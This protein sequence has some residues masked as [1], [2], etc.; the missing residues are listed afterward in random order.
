MMRWSTSPVEVDELPQQWRCSPPF[1]FFSDIIAQFFLASTNRAPIHRI[2]A[3]MRRQGANLLVAESVLSRADVIEEISALDAR[4]NGGGGEAQAIA[5]SFFKLSKGVKSLDQATEPNLLAHAVL[6]NYRVKGYT[7]F[8]HSYIY[9][10]ILP[11]PGKIP[12]RPLDFPRTLVQPMRSFCCTVLNRTFGITG[13]LYCQQND[14][15][16]VCAHSCLRMA[17]GST[18]HSTGKI[19]SN[20]I[21][22]LLGIRDRVP[23]LDSGQIAEVI[24]ACGLKA[25]VRTKLQPDEYL[26]ELAALIDSGY[27]ALLGFTTKQEKGH[28]NMGHVVMAFGH[29]RNASQWHAQAIQTYSGPK[30]S[31]YLPSSSWIDNFFI[32]DDNLGPYLSLSARSFMRNPVMKLNCVIGLLPEPAISSNHAEIV[33]SGV[34]QHLLPLL[35]EDSSNFWLRYLVDQRDAPILRSVLMTK[36]E[37]IEHLKCS[38][39]HDRSRMDAY[40]LSKLGSLDG[41][42]WMVEFSLPPLYTGNGSKLGEVLVSARQG[43]TSRGAK[44]LAVRLPGSVLSLVSD[45]TLEL[46]SCDLAS[47]SAIY[48]KAKVIGLR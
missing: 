27:M 35:R 7:N 46:D 2:C 30:S 31:P 3:L 14:T 5:F 43:A 17:I 15:L 48:E 34:L 39:G 10:A 32:H 20:Q 22:R 25:A 12:V 28:P 40:A 37:Y 16:H 47:H 42:F 45:D 6:I 18:Q 21:N 44:V 41:S 9:E 36:A 29:S 24:D 38:K 4:C 8:T 19:S 33:A 23:S 13:V 26:S 11:P 1:S